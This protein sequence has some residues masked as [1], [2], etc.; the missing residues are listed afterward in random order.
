MNLAVS[1]D[2][3]GRSGDTP[4]AED[5]DGSSDVEGWCAGSSSRRLKQQQRRRSSAT[6]EGTTTEEKEVSLARRTLPSV[7]F[8]AIIVGIASASLYSIINGGRNNNK[9]N[10]PQHS[11]VANLQ[12]KENKPEEENNNNQQHL[13][14]M[15][16]RVVTA[17]S[18]NGNRSDCR[19]MCD[20]Y[21]CCFDS[22]EDDERKQCAVYAGCE[23]L[24]ETTARASSWG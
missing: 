16:E 24:I 4:D 12:L 17:C 6:K 18:D 10:P 21:M 13:L 20:G 11:A 19:T 22:C 1:K 9:N 8:V 2:I 15:A 5:S 7:A 3:F 23:V 14:E